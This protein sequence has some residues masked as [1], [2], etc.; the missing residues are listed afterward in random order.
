M[1]ALTRARPGRAVAPDPAAT[2][3]ALSQL[4]QSQ[5]LPAAASLL[6]RDYGPGIAGYVTMLVRD[7]ALGHDAFSEFAEEL[8]KALP[9][10]RTTGSFRAWAYAIAHHCA[11]RQLRAVK[12]RRA[13]PLRDSE[14]SKL[15]EQARSVSLSLSRAQRN[16]GVAALR[17]LLSAEEQALLTLRLDRGLAWAEIVDI[18][19]AS[20]SAATLRKRF[21]RIKRRLR[22]AARKQGLVAKKS[23]AQK[24]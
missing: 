7:D 21:E 20:E 10:Y 14:W 15:A 19:G 4:W 12:R 22:E 2:E 5:Q 24:D 23:R 6:I 13:R 3:R 17:A 11:L 9:R 8:W 18:L 1:N 16:S